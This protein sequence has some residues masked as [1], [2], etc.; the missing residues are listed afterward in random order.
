MWYIDYMKTR[1]DSKGQGVASKL[2]DEFFERYVDPDGGYVHFGKMMRKEIGHLKDKM[3]KKYPNVGVI[4]GE[5]LLMNLLREYIR[6]LLKEDAIGFVNQ[7]ADLAANNPEWYDEAS[8]KLTKSAGRGIKRAFSDNADHAWLNTIKT[9]HWVERPIALNRLA[10]KGKDELST[11]MT[12][13]GQDFTQAYQSVKPW[14]QS[15]ASL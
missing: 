8:N 2:M 14:S 3:A 4:G 1:G 7:M 11:T 12:L 13:P 6:E 10:D 15:Q 9:V 5:V